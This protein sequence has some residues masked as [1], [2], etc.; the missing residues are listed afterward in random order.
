MQEHDDTKS[1]Y[2]P[3]ESDMGERD[4]PIHKST[5]PAAFNQPYSDFPDFLRITSSLPD[6]A[7]LEIPIDPDIFIQEV[8]YLAS[9]P[10]PAQSSSQKQCSAAAVAIAV[11]PGSSSGPID[12]P[13]RRGHRDDECCGD[14]DRSLPE[15]A[16]IQVDKRREIM[17][18]E[19]IDQDALTKN[20]SNE[21]LERRDEQRMEKGTKA[22][23]EAK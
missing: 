21:S 10:T 23:A 22:I 15:G 9:L 17:P 6:Q 16:D 1:Q 20:L 8:D 18:R 19:R 13:P 11:N 14:I 3:A 5:G 12:V 4:E 2:T 7:S